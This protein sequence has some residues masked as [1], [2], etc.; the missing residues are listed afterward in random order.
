MLGQT[1]QK[2]LG[3]CGEKQPCPG[4]EEI[5][6]TAALFPWPDRPPWRG[7]HDKLKSPVE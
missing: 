5:K 4:I 2:G 7:N 1:A 6:Q 3:I